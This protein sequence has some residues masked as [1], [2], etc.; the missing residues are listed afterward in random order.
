MKSKILINTLYFVISYLIIFLIY[1][2]I[3][4]RKRKT[5]K[6]GKKAVDIN[7][8][9]KK[10]NLDLN[11]INYKTIKWITT[12]INPLIISF[13]FVIVINIESFTLGLIIGFIIM[14]ALIYSIYEIIGRL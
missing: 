8:L 6:E 11:K 5:Y 7:Y 10:F 14:L 2:L 12:F 13:T 1:V 3:I 4:N 9:I